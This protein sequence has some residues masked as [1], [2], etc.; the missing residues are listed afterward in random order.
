MRDGFYRLQYK[1]GDVIGSGV[2]TLHDGVLAGCDPHYFL[3]GKYA[4][5]GSRL[6]GT[7]FFE[8]HTRRVNQNP[9][10]PDRFSVRLWGVGGKDY[11]QFEFECPEIPAINGQARF[12]WLGEYQ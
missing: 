11:G 5:H 2:L 9:V 12:T 8:R 4:K 1:T 10:V 3:N 6:E 7:L